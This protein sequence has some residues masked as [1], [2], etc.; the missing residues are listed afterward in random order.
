MVEPRISNP[1]PTHSGE[2]TT[3]EVFA[4]ITCPFTHVGLKQVL[5][6]VNEMDEPAE[7]IV[8]A[9]PLEWVNGAP[10]DVDAVITKAR[11]LAEQLGVDDFGGLS[12]DRWPASTIPALRIAAAGYAR[13]ATTGLAISVELR[14][15][16]FE[17][18]LDIGSPEVLAR[19]AADHD[20]DVPDDQTT[21]AVRADYED[22]QRR[23]VTGSPHFFVGADSFF[24]P[25]LDLGHDDA[26]HLTA[27]FDS[28]ALANFF[29]RIDA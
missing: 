11:A 10:L 4:D 9:W 8:R 14:A 27:R 20:L 13:D 21:Q 2:P 3:I 16:L 28:A 1:H 18:G 5:H 6:H 24:C 22:G 17:Q 12:A 25:A 23:G 15:A 7:V 29:A 19:I 26:G